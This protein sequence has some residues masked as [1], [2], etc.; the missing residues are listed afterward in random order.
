M[1]A[2][3][4]TSVKTLGRINIYIIRNGFS[5][6]YFTSFLKFKF[7]GGRFPCKTIKETT[8]EKMLNNMFK[9]Y[10]IFKVLQVA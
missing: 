2:K 8:K 3:L 1:L 10:T 4:F 7:L 9:M 6:N 5:N